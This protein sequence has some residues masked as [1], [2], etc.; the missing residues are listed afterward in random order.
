MPKKVTTIV[1]V[2][3]KRD[4]MLHCMLPLS[5]PRVEQ[6]YLLE[7]LLHPPTHIVT[8]VV[9]SNTTKETPCISRY[10][11]G[12]G[13]TLIHLQRLCMRCNADE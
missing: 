11:T 12:I 5:C 9:I 13:M 4:N 6:L 2:I 3:G 7:S 1:D 8:A 10:Y